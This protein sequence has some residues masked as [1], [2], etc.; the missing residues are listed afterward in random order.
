ML[1]HEKYTF[2]HDFSKIQLNCHYKGINLCL[3]FGRFLS[4]NQRLFYRYFLFT[5]TST[6][7]IGR[8]SLTDNM[9]E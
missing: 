7:S 3:Y 5:H 6:V 1:K 9:N 4:I 2:C 8:M